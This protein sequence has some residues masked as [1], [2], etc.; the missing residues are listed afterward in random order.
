MRNDK[1][2]NSV[3][4]SIDFVTTSV[5]KLLCQQEASIST[6]ESCTGGMLSEMITSIAGASDIFEMGI[7]SYSNRI[8]TKLLGVPK[9]ILEKYTE[10]SQQTAVAMAEGAIRQSGSQIGV[11]ITGIAGPTGGSKEKPVGT[12]YVSVVRKK[13]EN[14]QVLVK[15]LELYKE[16]EEK[17]LTR[18]MVRKLAT[19][20]ALEMVLEICEK[21]DMTK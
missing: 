17:K 13:N 6:A 18:S 10:V 2:D 15:N 19:L 9:E 12:V 14:K 16:V 20:R 3:T 5:V 8:K 4:K 11:G 7:I 1:N 21:S